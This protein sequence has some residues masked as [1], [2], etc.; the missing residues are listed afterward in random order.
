MQVT[1][2]EK[3][4]DILLWALRGSISDLGTEIADTENH[5][6]RED[7]KERRSILQDIVKRLS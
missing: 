6:Y 3:E 1:L 2:D 5:D 4:K 7:L